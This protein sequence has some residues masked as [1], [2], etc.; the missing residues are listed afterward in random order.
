MHRCGRRM[1][2][3]DRR[4]VMGTVCAGD[5]AQRARQ[6]RRSE[7]DRDHER[8]KASAHSILKIPG[9]RRTQPEH[10]MKNWSGSG[11]IARTS[12]NC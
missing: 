11:R 4:S 12:Q 8:D 10:F 3:V 6:R 2:C 7:H 5:V 1:M 9:F